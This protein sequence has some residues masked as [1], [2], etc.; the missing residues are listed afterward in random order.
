[1]PWLEAYGEILRRFSWR[2]NDP[3]I[4]LHIDLAKQLLT[5]SDQFLANLRAAL[6]S[7]STVSVS[8]RST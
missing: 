7:D 3:H 2:K 1:M 5:P 8:D 6:T 4:Q